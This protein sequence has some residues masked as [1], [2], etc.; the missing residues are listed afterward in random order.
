MQQ[1]WASAGIFSEGAKY[2]G[3][4]FEIYGTGT[5]EGTETKVELLNFNMFE[6]F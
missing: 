5:N 4:K 3:G 1:S 2:L 6:V